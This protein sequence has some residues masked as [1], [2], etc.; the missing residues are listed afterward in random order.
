MIFTFPLKIKSHNRLSAFGVIGTISTRISFWR[1]KM[2]HNRLSAFGV[3]GTKLHVASIM[4]L[5]RSQSPFGFWGD[6]NYKQQLY[7]DHVVFC[8]NRLS[9][10]GVIGTIVPHPLRLRKATNGHNRLSAFGVIGTNFRSKSLCARRIVS[11]SPFG[12]WGDWNCNILSIGV[13]KMEKSQSP[14]GFWGDWNMMM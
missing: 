6:W 9:A 2:G 11:Q 7:P 8:H 12:F 1:P 3:I 10:F 14:F 5:L 13:F 4:Q